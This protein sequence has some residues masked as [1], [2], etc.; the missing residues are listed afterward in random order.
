[1]KFYA[2]FLWGPGAEKKTDHEVSDDDGSWLGIVDNM[3]E[4][5]IF[6]MPEHRARREKEEKLFHEASR[7]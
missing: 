5:H 1:M 4:V 3:D 6:T 2:T 7:M